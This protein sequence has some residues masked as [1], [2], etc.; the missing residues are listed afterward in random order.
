MKNITVRNLLIVLTTLTLILCL[1]KNGGD[2]GGWP[3]A[4]AAGPLAVTGN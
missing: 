1:V 3:T 2:A 4:V